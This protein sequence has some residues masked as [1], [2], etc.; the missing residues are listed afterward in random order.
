MKK[1]SLMCLM[2][3]ASAGAFAQYF[4]TDSLIVA[5][6]AVNGT[7]TGLFASSSGVSANLLGFTYGGAIVE[8]SA[9]SGVQKAFSLGSNF[10]VSNS[11][12]SEAGINSSTSFLA[13]AG[14]N[15]TNGTASI[16]TSANAVRRVAVFNNMGN[17]G[18]GAVSY[19]DMPTGSYSGNN[20]RSAFTD[21]GST[22]YTAG[23]GT[24]AGWRTYN[25]GDATSTQYGTTA[26][27]RV[28]RTI[29]G[30]VYGST[31]SATGNGGT[32]VYKLTGAG[33]S[34]STAVALSASPYDFDIVSDNGNTYTLVAD[35]A[36]GLKVY[37]NGTLA[38][39]YAATGLRNFAIRKADAGFE[40]FG[41]TG[42]S[43][44]AATNDL[45]KLVINYG[46]LATST[47]TFSV[48]A[49]SATNTWF[50]G[51]EVVPEPASMAVLG[52]GLAGLAARRRRNK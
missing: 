27:V 23:N 8:T 49:T 12:T 28:I 25:N 22:L 26:N 38:K 46:T 20:F 43:T 50:R 42:S 14:Y 13:I 30:D 9:G 36:A 37:L 40:I 21:N 24:T 45:S 2:G 18:A 39:T 4:P 48:I 41:I 10:V 51:V 17:A 1:L 3:L 32:G 47:N 11:A 19:V 29:N 5:S 34:T 15:A 35:D 6:T 7:G 33:A 31:G 44:G 16:S 52:I